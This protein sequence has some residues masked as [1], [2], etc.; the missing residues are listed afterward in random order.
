MGVE[1][2]SDRGERGARVLGPGRGKGKCKDTMIGSSKSN[3][4]DIVNLAAYIVF[5]LRVE[6]V[7]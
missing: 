5:F 1:D 6:S 4:D 2:A 7:S 3:V